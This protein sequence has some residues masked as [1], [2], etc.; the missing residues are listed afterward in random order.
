MSGDIK[1]STSPVV[2]IVQALPSRAAGTTRHVLLVHTRGSTDTFKAI[3]DRRR[4]VPGTPFHFAYP[5]ICCS[6]SGERLPACSF[7][8]VGYVDVKSCKLPVGSFGQSTEQPASTLV[9]RLTSASFN[10]EDG[11]CVREITSNVP[12]TAL[13]QNWPSLAHSALQSNADAY[14]KTAGFQHAVSTAALDVSFVAS[15]ARSACAIRK[16]FQGKF[17]LSSAV[18]TRQYDASLSRFVLLCNPPTNQARL[19][20]YVTVVTGGGTTERGTQR[21]YRLTLACASNRVKQQQVTLWPSNAAVLLELGADVEDQ[22]TTT[23]MLLL[24]TGTPPDARGRVEYVVCALLLPTPTLEAPPEALEE[25]ATAH[26]PPRTQ[27]SLS[28]RIEA[29]MGHP[30]R[31]WPAHYATAAT[32]AHIGWRAATHQSGVGRLSLTLFC[33]HNGVRPSLYIEWLRERSC[34]KANAYSEIKNALVK[35]SRGE[36]L[37]S[38]WDLSE[39]QVTV[40]TRLPQASHADVPAALAALSALSA[41][42]RDGALTTGGSARPSPPP[43]Y[44]AYYARL[45]SF[46][47]VARLLHRP[48]ASSPFPL[49]ASSPSIAVCCGAGLC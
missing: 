20:A 2:L 22:L 37:G 30:V 43:D 19:G 33:L 36:S 29:A 26:V 21:P 48:S 40:T 24:I 18:P 44:A 25:P 6:S 41:S 32:A 4:A 5:S 28:E 10:S 49:C 38:T 11:L 35:L 27:L 15:S 12:T 16:D 1:T 31:S 46:D 8:F 42:S 7:G 3:R 39:R 45:Y 34:I 17:A 9:C 23:T 13:G 14:F 47:D